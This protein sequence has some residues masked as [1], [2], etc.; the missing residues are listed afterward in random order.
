MIARLAVVPAIGFA[1]TNV[2]GFGVVVEYMDPQILVRAA[3]WNK[4]NRI[5]LLPFVRKRGALPLELTP[6]PRF[7]Q[8]RAF[9]FN[10][11]AGHV[12]VTVTVPVPSTALS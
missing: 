5:A 7:R 8:I 1:S 2:I 9:R 4:L 12:H 6:G 10:V 3:S 11:T